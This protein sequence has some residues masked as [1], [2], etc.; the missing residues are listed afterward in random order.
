L[1]YITIQ[2]FYLQVFLGQGE[3][4]PVSEKLLHTDTYLNFL[5]KF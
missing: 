4:P 3:A 1:N 2:L 5:T